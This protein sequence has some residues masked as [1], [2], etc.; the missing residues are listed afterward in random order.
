MC[1]FYLEEDADHVLSPLLWDIDDEATETKSVTENSAANSELVK[2]FK[3]RT[4]I[5]LQKPCLSS[6]FPN[7]KHSQEVT[8]TSRPKCVA[9][10]ENLYWMVCWDFLPLSEP[11]S[12]LVT[13]QTESIQDSV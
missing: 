1:I 4:D 10:F 2:V 5:D 7:R 11:D 12:L 9:E 3:F 8:C 6:S 13:T